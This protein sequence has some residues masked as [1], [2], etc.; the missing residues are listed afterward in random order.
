MDGWITDNYAAGHERPVYVSIGNKFFTPVDY[1][2]RVDISMIQMD[3]G[4][5][6]VEKDVQ[7]FF[8]GL[9]S[10]FVDETA[11]P[12]TLP[13]GASFHNVLATDSA[14]GNTIT[15]PSAVPGSTGVR[16]WRTGTGLAVAVAAG[17]ESIMRHDT[18]VAAATNVQLATAG[19]YGFMEF[20]CIE[21][22]EW[23]VTSSLT[24]TYT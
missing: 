6:T 11:G 22:G 20:N 9:K 21:A 14:G 16:V 3:T 15:L 7:K 24:L 23:W 19:E 4:S 17:G 12:A 2:G 18:G 5:G 8:H 1:S 10:T 13:E